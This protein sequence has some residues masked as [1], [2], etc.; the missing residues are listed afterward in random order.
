MFDNVYDNGEYLLGK[1][2]NVIDYINNQILNEEIDDEEAIEILTE[3]GTLSP[4]TIVS[5]NYNHPMGYS[6]EYWDY[7]DI[8]NKP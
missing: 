1:V 7:D 3:L 6:Y 4:D 2:K 8:V 5:I